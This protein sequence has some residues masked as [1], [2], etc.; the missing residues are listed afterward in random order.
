MSAL[1][2]SSTHEQ[3]FANASHIQS[4]SQY[5][6]HDPASASLY[7]QPGTGGGKGVADLRASAATLQHRAGVCDELIKAIQ[8]ALNR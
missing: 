6:S 2:H 5:S 7:G 8:Q 3:Y 1:R 4:Y